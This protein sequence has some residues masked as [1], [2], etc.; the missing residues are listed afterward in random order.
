MKKHYEFVKL[1]EKDMRNLRCMLI[2]D[3]AVRIPF[4]SLV[5]IILAYLGIS[6]KEVLV[7]NV[8][9]LI[10]FLLEL[11]IVVTSL[12]RE[13]LHFGAIMKIHKSNLVH[14]IHTGLKDEHYFSEEIPDGFI[15]QVL[16]VKYEDIM[17]CRELLEDKVAQF[18]QNIKLFDYLFACLASN[19]RKLINKGVIYT[20]IVMEQLK[21]GNTDILSSDNHLRNL[22]MAEGS[23]KSSH[24]K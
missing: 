12:I 14:Y 19:N 15:V 8:F 7:D 22:V 11:E 3:I 10:F 1:N 18:C 17:Y 16:P 4:A 5:L 13:I 2:G 20:E 6:H 24:S 21:M 23:L 9:S